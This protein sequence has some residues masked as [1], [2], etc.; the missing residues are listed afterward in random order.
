[1][2]NPPIRA[3]ESPLYDS[4]VEPSP[5]STLT[6]LVS[7]VALLALGSY[8]FILLDA[9][10]D[11]FKRTIF[12]IFVYFV[13]SQFISVMQYGM[14]KLR[15][16]DIEEAKFQRRDHGDMFAK[17]AA[18]NRMFG[19]RKLPFAL[20]GIGGVSNVGG[21]RS[22]P[23]DP[24]PPG[25]GNWDNS[26][27]QNSVLQGLASLPAFYDYVQTSLNLCNKYDVP[28]E[29]HR[30]L[31]MF[32]EQ[33]TVSS[34]QRTVLW[35]PAVLKSMDSWQ[36][37]DAQE[38]FTRVLEAVE[39]ES[40]KYAKAI[41]MS[42]R[43]GLEC[44]QDVALDAKQTGTE[45]DVDPSPSLSNGPHLASIIGS[46]AQLEVPSPMDGM[47]AQGLICKTCGYTEGLSLTQFTCLTL[48]LGLR[49]ASSI[50]DLLD[51]YTAP[52]EV[53]GVE[54][55]RC[56]KMTYG[57]TPDQTETSEKSQTTAKRKP[58]LRSK[59]K[60]ITVGRLPKDLVF[61]INRS[62]FDDY[63]NQRKNSA[64]IRFPTR[65]DFLSRW[66]AP[67]N[68]ENDRIEAVYELRCVVTH[69][70]RHDNGHYVALGKRD[71]NWYSFNDEIVTKVTEEDVLNRSNGFIFFYEAVTQ[72]PEVR[73]A[74]TVAG[75]VAASIAPNETG[76]I[77][78]FSEPLVSQTRPIVDTQ[79]E[80]APPKDVDEV[81]TTS[82]PVSQEAGSSETASTAS[83]SSSVSSAEG[84]V[85]GQVENDQAVP[86]L[87]AL[88]TTSRV[89]K[90]QVILPV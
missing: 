72:V 26:C 27:Y 17:Q 56:T 69:Y 33:L 87:K 64:A 50:E 49:G 16:L 36:Q 85:D 81:E 15:L 42:S 35:T 43:A 57:E 82:S 18:L 60:Q 8:A 54:C 13:P 75:V 51:D 5:Y 10:P 38:Y 11:T 9:W 7:T 21:Y 80:A 32:L 76:S 71:K 3:Y 37:Q 20:G 25:L 46:R 86:V 4:S 52:E 61:H 90:E 6:K 59:A 79:V 1:M 23:R 39:K 41:R 47:T 22:A 77:S 12:E 30:A 53:D 84:I 63:G 62:I 2:N 88:A 68:V 29:T 67:L 14:V 70:G 83:D 55:D 34:P 40:L 19:Q 89:A 66:C 31:D 58:I 65:L 28:A 45:K 74:E 73:A 48:N 24:S 44:L 78:G